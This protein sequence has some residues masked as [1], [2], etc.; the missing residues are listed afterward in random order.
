MNGAGLVLVTAL[1]FGFDGIG[2]RPV[3]FDTEVIP[4]LT[5]AGCNA[6]SCHGAAV[7]RGGFHLSLLGAEAALDYDTI[8]RE[9]E[10]RRVDLARPDESL[11]LTKPSGRLEHEGGVPPQ[12]GRVGL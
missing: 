5:R 3:D 1:V 9:L 11:I 10:G 4:L 7:G 6:G 8:V 2:A 12:A